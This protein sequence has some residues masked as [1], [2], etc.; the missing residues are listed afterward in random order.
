MMAA[1]WLLGSLLVLFGGGF[2]V[3]SPVAGGFRRSFGASELNPLITILPLV[4]LG[5]LLAAL[6]VPGNRGRL[7]AGARAAVLL[8]GFCLW[9]IIRESATICFLVMVYLTAW[10]GF[11]GVS[12]AASKAT[13]PQLTPAQLPYPVLLVDGTRISEVCQTAAELTLRPEATDPYLAEVFRI[14]DAAGR[15][16]RI[17]NFRPA[18]PRP[19]TLRRVL[20]A[21]VFSNQ[22]FPVNFGLRLDRVLTPVEVVAQLKDRSWAVPAIASGTTN[23]G[24]HFLAYRAEY[25]VEYVPSRD[26]L[27]AGKTAPNR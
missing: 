2:V 3:L 12:L 7:H 27:T 19:S 6:I 25:F 21:T 23:Y 10:L 15:R 4:A 20:D 22:R 26:R 14:I 13:A 8:I 24:A 18:S 9:Q 17:E 16:H 5:L 1:R 11:H